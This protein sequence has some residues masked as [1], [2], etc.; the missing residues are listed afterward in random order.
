MIYIILQQLLHLL[1]K[2]K[3]VKILLNYTENLISTG[4]PIEVLFK[5]QQDLAKYSLVY[6]LIRALICISEPFFVLLHQG[7]G[8]F[9]Y[10]FQ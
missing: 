10:P 7:G 6:L 3:S 9:N 8:S 4:F 5:H 2:R 1:L